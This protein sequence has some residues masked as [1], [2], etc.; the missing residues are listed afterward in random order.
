MKDSVDWHSV[1]RHPLGSASGA[2]VSSK[3]GAAAYS[4]W[5]WICTTKPEAPPAG[6]TAEGTVVVDGG[7]ALGGGDE[8]QQDQP[9]PVCEGDESETAPSRTGPPSF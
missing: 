4:V 8:E 6:A 3:N 5:A 2:L 1:V 7:E 9:P